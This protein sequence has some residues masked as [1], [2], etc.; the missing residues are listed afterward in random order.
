[1]RI[2]ESDE[3]EGPFHKLLDELGYW[4]E[5]ENHYTFSL[6]PVDDV[7]RE[8]FLNLYRWQWLQKLS[9]KRTLELH[10]EVFEH[11]AK[12]PDD[13]KE[14]HWRKF[15]I[16]LDAIFRNQ[17]YRTELGPGSNDGG[18]DLRIY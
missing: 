8:N 5:M 10:A 1:M 14:L 18:I 13:M 12:H 3:I 11:F 16:L 17:G 9:G 7:R 15:E 4:Y 6:Y 2:Y